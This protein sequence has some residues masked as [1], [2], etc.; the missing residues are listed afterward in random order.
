MQTGEGDVP[1]FALRACLILDVACIKLPSII[2][3][4]ACFNHT[5]KEKNGRAKLQSARTA[6]PPRHCYPPISYSP[7]NLLRLLHKKR[8]QNTSPPQLSPIRTI[9]RNGFWPD[10]C[11]VPQIHR[12]R[13]QVHTARRLS[14]TPDSKHHQAPQKCDRPRDQSRA[15]A[16]CDNETKKPPLF[17][18]CYSESQCFFSFS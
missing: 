8:K 14:S 11:K 5:V 10:F 9:P 4:R 12:W 6:S 16:I 17:Y 1:V 7:D 13:L 18:T 3:P 2:R 15:V